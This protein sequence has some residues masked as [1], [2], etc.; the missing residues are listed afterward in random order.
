MDEAG[1]KKVDAILLLA[2]ESFGGRRRR[3][4]IA[5]LII[6]VVLVGIG[7]LGL[8]YFWPK[9]SLPKLV[10][11]AFDQVALPEEEVTLA[12]QLEP[13][14]ELPSDQDLSGCA[15]FFQELSSGGLLGTVTTSPAGQ[16]ALRARFPA[17]TEIV[18]R[19]PGEGERRRG[20]ESNKARVFVW[21][22]QSS[23]I[24]VDAVSA[25]ADIDATKFETTS[26]LDIPSRAG[27]AAV[28]RTLAAK[29]RVVYLAPGM[30]RALSYNKLSAWLER[31]AVPRDKLPD[32]PLLVSAG[33]EPAANRFA[34]ATASNL[35][36]RFRDTVIGI[37]A[38]P[39][40]ARQ[41]RE[42]GLKTYFL[43]E[44]KELADGVVAAGSWK[45]LTKQLERLGP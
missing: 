25:L 2:R 5:L 3:S 14:E 33:V 31:A 10:L 16:A 44:S 8:I 4:L 28:L 37:T 7:S 35:K 21:P 40:H 36:N 24:V 32:G 1:K 26:N 18:V 12:A 38:S 39:D 22:A 20:V 9:G 6:C 42:A 29:R 30:A 43:G 15:L 23:L 45:E 19:F 17:S 34:F 41:F 27:A 11:A 13:I